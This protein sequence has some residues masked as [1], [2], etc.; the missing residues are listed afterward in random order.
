M[1]IRVIN[2]IAADAVDTQ[3]QL[4]WDT[5]ATSVTRRPE[6]DGEFTLIIVYPDYEKFADLT[7]R[8]SQTTIDEAQHVT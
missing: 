5:G 3:E 7:A 8:L 4:A 6:P 1:G 2:N